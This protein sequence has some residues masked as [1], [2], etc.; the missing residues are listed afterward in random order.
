VLASTLRLV[1]AFGLAAGF[2]LSGISAGSASSHQG[3]SCLF[4]PWLPDGT[5]IDDPRGFDPSGPYHGTV[6][7]QNLENEPIN[8]FFTTVDRC[9]DQDLGGEQVIGLAASR[10]ITLNASQL[11]I[12]EGSGGGIVAAGRRTSDQEPAT[13]AGVQRQTSPQVAGFNTDTS[14]AHI[15]VTGYT[16]LTESG[17]DDEVVL[18]IAQTNSNWNTLIRVTNFDSDFGTQVEL[19]LHEAGGG[20]TLGPYTL[21]LFQGDTGTFD[22]LDLGVPDGWIGSA[23]ITTDPERPVAAVA[24]RVKNETS[25]LIINP[26]RTIDQSDHVQ[27]AG[28][29]FRDWFHWNTGI[30]IVNLENDVN[31]IDITFYGIDGDE[32]HSDS[33]SIPPNGMD[34]LYLPASPEGEEDPFVGSAVI[35]G[36]KLFHG[37]VDEVKYFGDDPDTGHAM[38]YTVDHQY[39]LPGKSL[40]LPLVQKGDPMTGGGDTSGIQIFNVTEHV[41]EVEIMFYDDLGVPALGAPITVALDP[42]EGYTAYTMFIDDLP[43]GFLGSAVIE[44]TFPL[45]I[46]AGAAIVAVSNLVNYDVQYDGSASFNLTVFGPDQMICGGMC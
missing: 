44:N 33:L 39:A 36:T 32:V 6:T 46:P 41:A 4:F 3:P 9:Q 34:F 15:T 11:G 31:E 43:P 8:V 5:A 25:M 45:E 30:S 16:A 23:V 29:V 10:S 22:L 19:V 12:P 7:I 27:F 35:E 38:S 1:L 28:L 13:I 24:E 40:A 37:A 2:F 14:D 26:S 42:Y 18:P 17:V 21:P 20:G